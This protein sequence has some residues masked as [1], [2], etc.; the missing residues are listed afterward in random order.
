MNTGVVPRGLSA[1]RCMFGSCR[2]LAPI[3]RTVYIVIVVYSGTRSPDK[4]V[5]RNVCD[6]YALVTFGAA[7]GKLSTLGGALSGFGRGPSTVIKVC[8]YPIVTARR[9]VS[10][11]NRVLKHSFGIRDFGIK[12]GTIAAHSGL[13]KCGPEGG[14]LCACPCGFLDMK[15]KGGGTRFECRFFSGLTGTFRYCM[16]I[17]VPVRVTLEPGKCGNAGIDSALG[18]RALVL[19]SCAVYD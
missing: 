11:G 2:S 13:G 15:A 6:N 17:R 18:G 8:V 7:S 9:A 4:G 10:S 12:V 19:S 3:L 5:V 14:G 1:N 16:P